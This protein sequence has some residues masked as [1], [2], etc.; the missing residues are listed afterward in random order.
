MRLGS[1]FVLAASI[2]RLAEAFAPASVTTHHPARK[3]ILLRRRAQE[4]E[5]DDGLIVE[6]RN[7]GGRRNLIINT[8]AGGLLAA[9]GVAAWE[10]FKL[11]VYTPSGWQRL[12]TTQFVAALGDPTASQGSGAENWGIWKEDPGPRGVWLRDY[13]ELKKSG[14]VAPR[15]WKFNP[16][17]FWV[18]EHGL[19]M[20][21]PS[22]PLKPGRY[23]VTGARA[24]TTGLTVEPNGR[25]KLDEGTLY[26]VTH[27]PCRSA[28]YN[29]ISADTGSPAS[30]NL[31]DF[32]VKPGAEMPPIPGTNK[33]D[34]AVLFV[35]GK[36]V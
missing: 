21:S 34:Y 14:G 24:I 11:Q 3:S 33:Q 30:A 6:H 20:E 15:G 36:E 22:F 27:L 19:I 4:E 17:D 25:W 10:L 31:R 18:E 13:E 35:I 16:D 26:D 1:L 23:L 5:D 9:S 32:P 8:I 12:P 7:D 28:R 29:P 2:C